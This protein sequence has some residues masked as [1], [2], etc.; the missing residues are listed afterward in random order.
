MLILHAFFCSKQAKF[1][2]QQSQQL[3]PIGFADSLQATNAWENFCA[4][5]HSV[6]DHCFTK[7]V[8]HP[9]EAKTAFPSPSE[10]P[11]TTVN[12]AS[13]VSRHRARSASP[14]KFHSRDGVNEEA[15]M[16]DR[17]LQAKVTLHGYAIA[18]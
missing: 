12:T 3:Q 4:K 15:F 18:Y 10:S 1:K 14:Q 17:Q 2:A 5:N 13:I 7:T 9:P 8:L 11:L 6:L 16:T